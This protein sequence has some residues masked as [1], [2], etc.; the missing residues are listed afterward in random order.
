MAISERPF[1]KALVDQMPNADDRDMYTAEIDKQKIEKAVAEIFQ[2]GRQ[3]VLGLI[4][5]LAEPGSDEDVKPHYALHC[6]TNHVLIVKDQTARK[7]LSQTMAADL[8]ADRPDYVKAF[9]C[10]ELQWAGGKEAVDAIGKL[11]LN[12]QLV[13]AAAMALVAIGHG[14][15]EQFRAALPKAKGKCRLNV[16]QGLGAVE[17]AGSASAL[18]EAIDD[19]DAE[20]RLAAGWAL[21]RIGN[22]DSVDLLLDAAEVEPGWERVQATKHCL[23][24]AEKLMA[25][26]QKDQAKKIYEHLRDTRDDPSER[27]IREAAEKALT[28]R[29]AGR[30]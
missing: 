22:A 10:Q 27:Y 9:L 24:L 8:K 20:V 28:C 5:M 30:S 17:D 14:A 23:L 29:V 19:G 21:A 13:E 6:L 3:Y 25:A 16:V 15:A 12:E 1:V 2:G 7:E 18:R 11:L 26:G 4:D